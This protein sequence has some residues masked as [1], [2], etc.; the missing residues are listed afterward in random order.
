MKSV[1]RSTIH[2]PDGFETYAQAKDR[3]AYKIE[4]L[5]GGNPKQRRIAARLA[6]CRKGNRCNCGACDVCERRFRLRLLRQLTPILASRPHWTRASIVPADLLFA[7]GELADVDLNA[8]KAKVQKRFERWTLRN[9][10]VI[11]G[12]D[13][14]SNIQNN[15]KVGWQL[16]LYMLIEGEQT[17]QMEEAVKATFRPEA[18][19]LVPYHF[20]QVT[21]AIRPV[22]YLYKSIFWRRSR[23]TRY[24]RQYRIRKLQLKRPELRELLEFLG[25]YPVG[26]RL[27]LRGL[28]RDGKSLIVTSNQRKPIS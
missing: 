24:G 4:I 14:S 20:K 16:H 17:V 7:P 8:L 25:R 27:I 2:T 1:V 10:I 19:A 11:A 6:R 3:R 22:T 5:S 15:K 9:R 18:T 26:A 13:I 23:Y 12:I 28:R 21:G